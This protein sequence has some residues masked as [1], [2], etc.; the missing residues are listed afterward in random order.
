MNK[1]PFFL[2]VV[3]VINSCSNV[4]KSNPTNVTQNSAL[5]DTA[6]SNDKS[7]DD[8]IKSNFNSDSLKY[9][10]SKQPFNFTFKDEKTIDGTS[11]THVEGYEDET[12]Y[13]KYI[14]LPN[15]IV[16]NYNLTSRKATSVT[17]YLNHFKTNNIKIDNCKAL[18]E[19]INF[20][21]PDAAKYLK[22][23]F[24][25][26]FYD[27]VADEKLGSY[28]TNRIEMIVDHNLFDARRIKKSTTSQYVDC[29]IKFL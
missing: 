19:F 13:Q 2:L 11:D 22:V 16:I 27:E 18:I 15:D 24:N 1:F 20:F 3:L 29:T 21:D 23:N 4:D 17:F 6:V 10:F 8:T 26:I 12:N 7:L 9:S 28:K 14:D 5:T 25:T